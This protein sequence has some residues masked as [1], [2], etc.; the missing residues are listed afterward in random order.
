MLRQVLFGRLVHNDE[1]VSVF[2]QSGLSASQGFADDINSLNSVE[3]SNSQSLFPCSLSDETTKLLG[4]VVRE[5]ENSIGFQKLTS[6]E[7]D[8]FI[9]TAAEKAPTND[10][11]IILLRS[12]QL[13]L[14]NLSL[15][16]L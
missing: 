11:Q 3:Q 8:E 9:A 14:L 10:S 2:T 16:K 13:L 15:I 5:L 4:D 12:A 1:V 6:F 7:L